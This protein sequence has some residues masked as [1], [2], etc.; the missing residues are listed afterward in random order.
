MN[1][2]N[3]GIIAVVVIVCAAVAH[4]FD[5][6]IIASGMALVA[7]LSGYEVGVHKRKD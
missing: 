2:K 6:V 3:T 1:T 4:G 7:G 5:G